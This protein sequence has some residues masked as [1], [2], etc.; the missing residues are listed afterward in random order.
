M[1]FIKWESKIDKQ[2]QANKLKVH[3]YR[4]EIARYGGRSGRNR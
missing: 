4:E 1:K 2:K 3:K